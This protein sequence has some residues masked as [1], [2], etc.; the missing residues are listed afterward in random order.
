M[1][2]TNKKTER[3]LFY[4]IFILFFSSR[5]VGAQSWLIGTSIFSLCGPEGL[6]GEVGELSAKALFWPTLVFNILAI[7]AI[8]TTILTGEA[9]S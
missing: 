5:H 7:F 8:N 9:L 3:V 4:F 1:I 6:Q 2:V